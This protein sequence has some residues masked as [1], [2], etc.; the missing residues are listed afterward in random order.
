ML[1]L[2]LWPNRS[3][4]RRGFALV[5]AVVAVGAALLLVPFLATPVVWGL[6]PFAAIAP[7]ALWAALRRSYADG[8]LREELRLWPDLI[9][10]ERREADGAVRRWHAD[11]HWVRVRLLDEDAPVEKYLTLE[12]NGREIELG[13]FLSPP[14]REAL[15]RD[16]RAALGRLQP[17]G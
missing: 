13:A 1:A 3:L 9:T 5:V 17:A 15:Y 7:L 11:P 16:L 12:G 8:R 6:L 4:P 2:T 14:E 10:V